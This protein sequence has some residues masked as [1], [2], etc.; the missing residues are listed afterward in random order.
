[1]QWNNKKAYTF[2]SAIKPTGAY[3]RQY[4]TMDTNLL[5]LAQQRTEIR[6]I[7]NEG[8]TYGQR[9]RVITIDGVKQRRPPRNFPTLYQ[10]A[11]KAYKG[12]AEHEEP[13]TGYQTCFEFL[14]STQ[15]NYEPELILHMRH[16]P[17]WVVNGYKEGEEP[18]KV[19]SPY[20]YRVAYVKPSVCQ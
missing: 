14:M 6:T 3:V 12:W 16:T 5:S 20:E 11:A 2:Q 1:M 8:L 10:L 4:Q 18:Y 15:P 19:Y 9:D 7:L 13:T 17:N